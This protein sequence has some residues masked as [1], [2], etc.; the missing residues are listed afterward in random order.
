MRGSTCGIAERGNELNAREAPELRFW[1][2]LLHHLLGSR[3]LHSQSHCE[4]LPRVE[5]K[6]AGT[7]GK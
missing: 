4:A 1:L 3:A 7:R 6:Q 5:S 2:G